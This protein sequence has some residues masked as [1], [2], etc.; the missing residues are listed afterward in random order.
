LLVQVDIHRAHYFA[1]R[2][3]KEAQAPC[4]NRR[5]AWADRSL[6]LILT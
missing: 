6:Y 4:Q 1:P 3:Q 5:G 2:S